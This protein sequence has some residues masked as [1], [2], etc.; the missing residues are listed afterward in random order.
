MDVP[1]SPMPQNQLHIRPK[2]GRNVMSFWAIILT[3]VFV[4]LIGFAFLL[5]KSGLVTIP[6]FSRW[7]HGPVPTREIQTPSR[8]VE[9][10]KQLLGTRFVTEQLRGGTGPI[11][12]RVSEMELTSVLQNSIRE[13]L[14]AG[15]D[16]RIRRTQ[17]VI[18]QD[19]VELLVE[20]TRAGIRTDLLIRLVPS[21]Q[22]SRLHF[23]PVYFSL[24]D[25]PLPVSFA[26]RFA[27]LV[28][29]RDLGEWDVQS[30]QLQVQKVGI[31]DGAI[32]IVIMRPK[33]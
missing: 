29:S 6:V 19:S 1:V 8:T 25:I 33:Q 23:E 18:L 30:S 9:E 11:V 15:E 26:E 24:G 10:F 7:Y 2:I 27:S 28:F 14:A 20:L 16:V 21:I 32:E 31:V 12:I 13:G 3:I 22:G 5:A 4:I 17:V